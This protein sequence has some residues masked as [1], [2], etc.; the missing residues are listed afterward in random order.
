MEHGAGISS[1][2]ALC[3]MKRP[4]YYSAQDKEQREVGDTEFLRMRLYF[5]HSTCSVD[6]CKGKGQS[7][8]VRV[9]TS[10]MAHKVKVVATKSNN[11]NLFPGTQVIG[12]IQPPQIDL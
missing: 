12:E 2:C 11:L 7:T 4:L 9:K 10:K 3:F 6:S 1:K 8:H 5:L